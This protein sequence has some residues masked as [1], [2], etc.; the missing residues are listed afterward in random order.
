[1]PDPETSIFQY[2]NYLAKHKWYVFCECAKRGIV[3]RGLVHDWSKFLPSEFL[4]YYRHFYGQQ[5]RGRDETGYYKPAETGD[6]DFELAWLLHVSRNKHHWQ[7]WILPCD[8]DGTGA[9][10]DT[11]IYEMPEK[12]R[13]EMLA[14]WIG[15]GKAQ[16]ATGVE[17][18]WER[19][20]SKLLLGPATRDWL[21]REITGIALRNIEKGLE[22]D[23]DDDE[24]AD[25]DLP[26]HWMDQ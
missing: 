10:T 9:P 23:D 6:Y 26:K 16:G 2:L 3:W 13:K 14:D 15:A 5:D 1:M 4:P 11:K 8:E 19:N 21:E 22:N 17:F 25:N 7:F 12:Y 24:F 18:W 20:R